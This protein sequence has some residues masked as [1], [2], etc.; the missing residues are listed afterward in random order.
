MKSLDKKNQIPQWKYWLSYLFEQH[1]ESASSDFNPHLYVSLK[2]GRL[3]L[4]T[5][6]AIYSY[7]DLYDNFRLAFDRM[8]LDLV[9][10][11]GKNILVLGLGLGSIPYILEKKRHLILHYTLVEI[12]EVVAYLA[13]KYV[14]SQLSSP[15]A[16][17]CADANSFVQQHE[18]LYDL[19]AVDIFE[20]DIIPS[21]FETLDFL[22]NLKSRLKPHG[23]IM[24]NRLA[25]LKGDKQKTELFFNNT[26]KKV[27]PKAQFL[28]VK[29]NAMLF[30]DNSFLK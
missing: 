30:N 25:N 16:V 24:Y 29:G 27:F 17:Y 10:N 6:N 9:F 2:K 23:V 14:T 20:D 12:D 3:Q 1:L 15:M 26:F 7:Q 13:E 4:S 18:D 19:I 21:K 11:Q 28:K 8:N 5:A 22:R